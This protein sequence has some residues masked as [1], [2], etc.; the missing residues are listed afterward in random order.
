MSLESQILIALALDFALGDPAWAPHP[1][2]W[3]GSLAGKLERLARRFFPNARAAGVVTV[4]VTLAVA[5]SAAW[6]V[7]RAAW[8]IAP[9][10]GE[11]ASILIL[12]SMFAARDL[13]DHAAAVKKALSDG[14]IERARE[15][16]GRMVGRDTDRLD[17]KGV[18]RACVESVAENTVD[19]V[20]APLFYAVIGGPVGAALY[21][22]ANTMDSMFGHKN[23]RYL[24]FGWAAARLDDALN[25]V[26]ARLT[27]PLIAFSAFLIGL[28]FK[29]SVRVLVR[30]GGKSPSPNAGLAEAAAAG[31]LRLRLGGASRYGGVV[32]ERP[33]L[34]DPDR[35][36]DT[37]SI[38]LSVR[39]AIATTVV[40][41]L[42]FTSA[43]R[44]LE[45]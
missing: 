18:I 27:A 26:P 36:L 4:A 38:S 24:R 19:G 5:G 30:D 44:L 1:V 41:A 2:R 39:L 28:D 21:K 17:E 31:A 32:S 35:E 45:L 15:Q 16:V 14:D 42:V 29:S 13:A 7:V 9:W 37:Q 25:F 33:L 10:M 3:I 8:L 23:E 20:T 6:G 40:A 12:Y 11:V 43:G 34:G 22:A